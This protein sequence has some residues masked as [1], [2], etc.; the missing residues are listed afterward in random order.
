MP[1][2]IVKPESGNG[3]EEPLLRERVSEDSMQSE[4]YAAQLVERIG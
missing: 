3:N 4:H 2:I 1:E